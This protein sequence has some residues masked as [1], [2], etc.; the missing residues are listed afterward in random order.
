MAQPLVIVV[1]GYIVGFPLGGMTWHHLNYLIGLHEMGHEV[2][3]LEDSGSFS[4]PYNPSTWTCEVDSHYGRAYLERTFDEVGLPKRYCYY[5]EF[6]DQHYGMTREQLD[7]VLRRADLLLCVSG[8][9]PLRK[10]RPRPRRTAVIDTDPVFTQLRLGHDADFMAYY[11]AFDATATFGRLIG[12]ERSPLPTGGLHWIPTNQPIAM[13]HWPHLPAKRTHFTTIGKW[14][15][16]ADRNL[17]YGGRK[18]RSSKGI[19]W[20]KMMDLPRRVNCQMS[21]GMGG[22]PKQTSEQFESHGWQMLD[23]E[24]ASISP[25][26]YRQFIQDSGGE[27]TVAKEIYAGLPSGWFSDRSAAYLASGR[28]VVTQHSG[29]DQWLPT[30]EGLFSYQTVDEAANAI[31]AIASDYPR[32]SAAARRVAEEYFDSAKVLGELLTRVM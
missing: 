29:F 1:G 24:Q 31:N 26:A 3:F 22:M 20:L 19:E 32:H 7:D 21:L 23:A 2:Y 15:H 16:A 17:E 4:I 25:A 27:F 6:E 10:N 8:V 11:K 30:G 9:T 18:Y 28:P 13:R 12:T 14:E 5:S